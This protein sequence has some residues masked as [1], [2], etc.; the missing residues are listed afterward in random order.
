M[1]PIMFLISF[2]Q[3]YAKLMITL[4]CDGEGAQAQGVN[5]QFLI[6]ITIPK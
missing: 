5:S 3:I 4:I 1:F 6:L 2:P